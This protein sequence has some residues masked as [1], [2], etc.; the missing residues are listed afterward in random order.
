MIEG[1]EYDIRIEGERIGF[2]FC[3]VIIYHSYIDSNETCHLH[4]HETWLDSQ[5]RRL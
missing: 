5:E 2:C 1:F 3:A 4:Y